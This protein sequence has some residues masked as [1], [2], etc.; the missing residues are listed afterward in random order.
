MVISAIIIF[1]FITITVFVCKNTKKFLWIIQN[2]RIFYTFAEKYNNDEKEKTDNN[3]LL[4]C[5]STV[6]ATGY[7]NKMQQPRQR[8]C[9]HHPGPRHRHRSYVDYAGTK[10]F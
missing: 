6:F 4:Q 9:P 2:I 1:L 10:V 8:A 7:N 3:S 5:L